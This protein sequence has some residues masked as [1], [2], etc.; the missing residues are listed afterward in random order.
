MPFLTQPV[1][2]SAQPGE[3]MASA[4]LY[5]DRSFRQPSRQAHGRSVQVV[6]VVEYFAWVKGNTADAGLLHGTGQSTHARDLP[7][8]MQRAAGDRHP[9][10]AEDVL[11]GDGVDEHDR[12]PDAT[13]RVHGLAG[14]PC[15]GAAS[16]RGADLRP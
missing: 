14:V 13:D 7:G 15:Y 12:T 3:R 16:R 6:W 4:A 10:F 1:V 9:A 8:G 5:R 11:C 2:V